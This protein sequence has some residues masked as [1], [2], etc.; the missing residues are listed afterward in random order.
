MSPEDAGIAFLRHAT[1]KL[2]DER[3]LE[4][5]GTLGFRGEALA[6]ISSVSHIELATCERGADLGVRMKLDAGEIIDMYETGCPSGTT[7][8]VRGLFY[9]TPARLKFM[10]SDRSEGAACVQAALRC[11][12]GRPDSQLPLHQGRRGGVLHPRRRAQGERRVL[13]AGPRPRLRHARHRA[14]GGASARQRLRDGARRGARQPLGA[15]LLL[16]RAAISAPSC[17]RRRWSRPTAARC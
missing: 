12:L 3:G 15:V 5:I 7:M 2:Q 10:K 11:A 1:S 16:Q 14:R 13:P 4:A 17:S 8:I 6:A 9:N